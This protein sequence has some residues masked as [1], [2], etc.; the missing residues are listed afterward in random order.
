ML[1]FVK[2]VESLLSTVTLYV[3]YLKYT[4]KTFKRFLIWISYSTDTKF[5][6]CLNLNLSMWTL[7]EKLRSKI[8]LWK[9]NENKTQVLNVAQ[10][11]E[12]KI[13]IR[14]YCQLILR[15]YQQGD[16]CLYH[17][18]PLSQLLL[19][20]PTQRRVSV[21]A[22][23]TRTKFHGEECDINTAEQL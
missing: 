5:S 8:Y 9:C 22:F 2:F 6:N 20:S 15:Q 4:Y 17:Q 13:I 18:L 16:N 19:L 11:D 10:I 21:S 14:N 1:Q 7:S 23:G 12:V 3:T